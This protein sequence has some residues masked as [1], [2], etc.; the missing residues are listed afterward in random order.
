[1]KDI[2]PLEHGIGHPRVRKSCR[3][4][5]ILFT[6]SCRTCP[7]YRGCRHAWR[8]SEQLEDF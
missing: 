6:S 8:V 4:S 7:E 2:W 3:D 1:M 5:P